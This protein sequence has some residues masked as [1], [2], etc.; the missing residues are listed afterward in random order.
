MVPRPVG[1]LLQRRRAREPARAR[2]PRRSL[3]RHRRRHRG[4]RRRRRGA[5][6]TSTAPRVHVFSE[7]APE[8]DRGADPRRRRAAG[9]AAAR[10]D[11]RGR[12]RLGAR[13]RQGDAALPREPGADAA[14]A[15]RCRSSTRASASPTTRRSSTR[16]RL[17]AVPDDG[18]HRLGGLARRGDHRRR[19]QGDARRLLAGAR[20]GDRRPDADAHDAAGA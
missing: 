5:R 17:V 9:R 14:R 15:R 1:H 10:P 6:A 13:R 7:V 12:R 16:V 4:A 11:R 8:P 18:G 2:R 20:H 19:A 3:R